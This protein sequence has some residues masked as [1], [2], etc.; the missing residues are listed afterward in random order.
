MRER[1][2]KIIFLIM[3][4]ILALGQIISD[5]YLPS[6]PAIA[7]SLDAS[8][9]AT[10]F[11]LSI[12]M[13]GFAFS[14]LFY[15]PVS[16]GIGRKKPLLVGLILC[17]LGSIICL[18]GEHIQFIIFGRFIQGLGA[19]STLTLSSAVLRD[20]FEGENLAKYA[21]YS[22]L[23]GVGF[24]AT[25]PLL[26]GYL[27]TYFDW[28]AAFIFMFSYTFISF[29]LVFIWVPETNIHQHK[30]HLIPENIK[31]NLITLLSSPIFIGYSICSLLVYGAIL[32]WLTAGPFL[33]QGVVGLTPISFGWTYILTGVAFAAGA[34]LNGKLVIRYGINR[35]LRI[36]LYCVLAAAILM[37]TCKIA[38]FINSMV[39]MGPVMLMMFGAS[40][41]FPN[42]SAGIFH[43]F[44]K[45]AGITSALFYSSRLFGGAIFSAA[46]ALMPTQN[47]L[48]MA[49]AFLVS[50]ILSLLIFHLTIK[51]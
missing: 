25:A 18:L 43:P 35:M 38:G 13:F 5:V 24:L 48:P 16:D 17:L 15:G 29:L 37:I 22:A 28:H 36:G 41:V 26:G 1:R 31:K 50:A 51:D 19:G 10:Q 3:V 49:S 23:I 12:Y 45:I 34:F 40:L 4:T 8:V 30:N 9:N 7:R 21:S 33:L 27:Q 2:K 44:P 11:S 47:Q 32:A 39:I 42:C 20:L 46:L 14:Q 6:L